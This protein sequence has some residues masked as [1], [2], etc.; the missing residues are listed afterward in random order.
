MPT[1]YFKVKRT[2]LQHCKY[3]FINQRPTNQKI[4][5]AKKLNKRGEISRADV[6]LTVHSLKM[7]L[8]V[9]LHLK[10]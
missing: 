8:V 5:L 1:R 2:Q 4:E 7:R 3:N 6:A 10:L 9:I